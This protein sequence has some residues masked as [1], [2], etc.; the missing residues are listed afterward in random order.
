MNQE[1]Q[2]TNAMIIHLSALSSYFIPLGSLL[3]PL[4][5]WQSFKKDNSYVDHHGKELS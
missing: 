5:L 1:S 4:I 2:N 3:L